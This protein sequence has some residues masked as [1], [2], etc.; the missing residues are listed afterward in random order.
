LIIIPGIAAVYWFCQFYFIFSYLPHEDYVASHGVC[1]TLFFITADV[2][3]ID[4]SISAKSSP[5]VPNSSLC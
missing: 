2:P 5:S 4:V 1:A 3:K